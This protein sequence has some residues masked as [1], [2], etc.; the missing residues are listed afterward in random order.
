MALPT[1]DMNGYSKLRERIVFALDR[2]Q[3]QQWLDFKESQPWPELKW[4]LLKTIMA[5]ANL[6]DGGLIVIG[7]SERGDA[8]D[9]TGIAPEHL[10]T[11]DSDDILDQ[12]TKYASPVVTL[13]VVLHRHD[14]GKEYLAINVHRFSETPVVCKSN[15]PSELQ[16]RDRITAGDVFV[17][18]PG[19]PQTERVM[20][21]SRL[22]ELLELAAETRARRMLEVAHRVGFTPPES[23]QMRFDKELSS[24][25]DMPVPIKDSAYWRLVIRPDRY[26][27]E[28]IPTRSDCLKHVEKSRVQLRGWDFPHLSNRDHE[29]GQGSNSVAS[30]CSFLG[31]IEYWR[32]FQSGQFIHYSV[33]TETVEEDWREKLRNS[34]KSQLRYLKDIDWDAVP[35]F[36]SITNVLYKVTEYFEFA[37]RLVQAGVLEGSVSVTLELHGAKGFVLATEMNRMWRNYCVAHENE[38]GKSWTIASDRLIADSAGHALSAVVW[39]FESFGWMNPNLEVLQKDQQKFLKREI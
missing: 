33:V 15:G 20:D 23:S 10:R 1:T 22:H 11:F 21:A 35:G 34:A 31:S 8:W 2:C 26:V 19:K 13:D 18:P 3:E 9:L 39:F 32:F 25:I 29:V 24:I 5:M 4:R 6:R 27:H 16:S 30:W 7:I 17:R 36:V 12:V 28:L 38:L 37:A 14:D